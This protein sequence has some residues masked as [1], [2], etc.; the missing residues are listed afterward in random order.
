MVG[1]GV[2]ATTTLRVGSGI[3]VGT[4]VEDGM[5]VDINSWIAIGTGV[6][7][8]IGVSTS[9]TLWA[10]A[11]VDT[12][13][14]GV[15]VGVGQIIP[16]GVVSAPQAKIIIRNPTSTKTNFIVGFKSTTWT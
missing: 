14:R 11:G 4:G 2:P 16:T 15:G 10:G 5:G 13:T 6:M 7:V 1:T 8:G 12:M 9:T 3:I